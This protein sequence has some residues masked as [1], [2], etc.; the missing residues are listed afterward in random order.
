MNLSFWERET[1]FEK[2]DIAIIGAGIVGL[3]AAIELKEKFPLKNITVFE[4]GFL[5][6]GAS[7]KNAGFACFGSASEIL[8]D[9]D[10]YTEDEVYSLIE[11]RWKGLLKLKKRLG[12][13]RIDYQNSGG[14]EVF[15]DSHSYEKCADFLPKINENLKGII[16]ATIY[17]DRSS[18][19]KDF[20]FNGVNHLIFN[21]YEGVLNA[22]KMMKALT[23]LA[24]K[25]GV[26]VLNGIEISKI[27]NDDFKVKI[28]VSDNF[29]FFAKKV[30]IANNA[31]ANQF[32][33]E[34]QVKPGRGQ[35]IIT[36]PIENLKIK[37]AFHLEEGYYYFRNIGDRLLLGG[38]RNLDFKT[39]ETT[40]FGTTD[41]VMNKLNALLEDFI[42]PNTPYE[43]DYAW[44]GIMAFGAQQ[45]PNIKQISDSIYCAV[46][47]QGMGVALGSIEGEM[48]AHLI[49]ESI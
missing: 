9:L 8:K 34:L 33:P 6:T 39:E 12:E 42:L 21:Q 44:S 47:C 1:Y 46:K 19:I 29:S 22:G 7:T 16:G 48:A 10:Q 45:K 26:E 25:K 17:N 23:E 11:L 37:G 36:K 27:E 2:I 38:G 43:I 14:Y 49:A 18:Y 24:L 15:N 5:P 3:S 41:L 20:G 30:L 31:F 28:S 13:Q 4:R 40:E 32:L 35:V